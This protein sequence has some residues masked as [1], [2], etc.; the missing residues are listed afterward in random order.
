MI[1]KGLT[2][3][4]YNGQDGK[5]LKMYTTAPAPDR[6][7]VALMNGHTLSVKI[8]HLEVAPTAPSSSP[9][10]EALNTHVQQTVNAIEVEKPNTVKKTEKPM[11][12]E[13]P[14]RVHPVWTAWHWE[15]RHQGNV[16]TT[17]LSRSTF[18]T[19]HGTDKKTI[20]Q[21]NFQSV[22]SGEDDPQLDDPCHFLKDVG[23]QH[24]DV[25]MPLSM[26]RGCELV[27]GPSQSGASRDAS[28]S[29]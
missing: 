6:I 3:L 5:I 28:E 9:T 1:L 21:E 7:P 24:T 22:T 17:P 15:H 11:F 13:R 26:T 14:N 2:A 29:D 4:Q 23:A 19:K 25:P 12:Q 16:A 8:T 10:Q 20:I 18:K 27:G